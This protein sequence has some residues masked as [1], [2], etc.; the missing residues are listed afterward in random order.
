MP[1]LIF[2]M[3]IIKH[4]FSIPQLAVVDG[5]VVEKEDKKETYQFTL[6]HKG[7]G[8][9]EDMTGTPLMDTLLECQGQSDTQMAKTIMNS[10]FILNL[11][12][13]S[14]IRIGKD[15]QIHNNRATAEEFKKYPVASHLNDLN[16]TIK[17]IEMAT[18]CVLGD[19]KQNPKKQSSKPEKK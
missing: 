1:S 7:I 3:K 17:L 11:A 10:N 9:F 2:A 6:L 14:Y 5:E 16:F 12:A 13:A 4:T 18:D 15:G 19:I 8:V